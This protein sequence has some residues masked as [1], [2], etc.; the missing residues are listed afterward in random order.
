MRGGLGT[1]AAS[2]LHSNPRRARRR[3][4]CVRRQLA[5][6]GDQALEEPGEEVQHPGVVARAAG[7]PGRFWS[8][9]FAG[10]QGRVDAP[11]ALQSEVT[12]SACCSC[13]LP[14]LAGVFPIQTTPHPTPH[15]LAG[16]RRRLQHDPLPQASGRVS[17]Q[18]APPEHQG[19]R[20]AYHRYRQLS[21]PG[22]SAVAPV[23]PWC[24]RG[25]VVTALFCCIVSLA[26]AAAGSA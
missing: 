10:V 26:V 18:G 12:R 4:W 7:Q 1:Q 8:T 11:L 19:Q 5:A 3:P 14:E 9:D 25:V 23:L 15:F 21:T 17:A 2:R 13:T 6:G 16:A 22:G 20:P 24:Y